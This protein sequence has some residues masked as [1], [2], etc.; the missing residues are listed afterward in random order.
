MMDHREIVVTQ[1]DMEKLQRLIEARRAFVMDS[2]HLFELEQELERATVLPVQRLPPDVVTMN[3][4]V[5]VTDLKTG[6]RLEYELVFP[7]DADLSKN[8]ISILA[9]I[10]T[11][12][13]GYRSG[14]TVEWNVPGG[15]RQ[16]RIDEV[17]AP[18]AAA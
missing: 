10:A 14:A 18:L 1:G 11:A 17:G 13:L 2:H 6:E 3:S 4:R 9:P 12:L 5:A 15:K 8:R 7:K 16:L